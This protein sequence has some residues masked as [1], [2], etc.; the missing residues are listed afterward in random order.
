MLCVVMQHTKSCSELVGAS[1]SGE[2]T[3]KS[4][5]QTI[6]QITS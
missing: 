2:K 3:F 4:Y 1:K 6:I 5:V